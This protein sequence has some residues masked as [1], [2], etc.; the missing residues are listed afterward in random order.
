MQRGRTILVSGCVALVIGACALSLACRSAHRGGPPGVV[1]ATP[2][3]AEEAPGNAE[4]VLS[5]GLEI[6][7]DLTVG[8][9]WEAT[10]PA[11]VAS[12]LEVV[13][14]QRSLDAILSLVGDDGSVLTAD[15]AP[16]GI[17]IDE[18]VA[19]ALP[20]GVHRLRLQPRADGPEAGRVRLRIE[21]LRPW[22]A[23]DERRLELVR[24][25][26][27]ATH[28]DGSFSQADWQRARELS[29]EELAGWRAVADP[30]AI[31][32]TLDRLTSLER[33]LGEVERSIAYGREAVAL[34]L[35]IADPATEAAARYWLAQ[36][37][38]RD[39]QVDAA[40]HQFALGLE[41]AERAGDLRLQGRILNWQGR[42]EG[43]EGDLKT[44]GQLFLR[45]LELRTSAH[46]V[47]GI[48]SMLNNLA[49]MEQHSGD[50][51]L[52]LEYFQRSLEVARRL[53][54]PG[55]ELLAL[56]NKASLLEDRGQW[57][58][59]MDALYEALGR[60]R[61]IGDPLSE[62]E[63]SRTLASVLLKLGES[64]SARE[65]LERAL[66]I[67]RDRKDSYYQ[68]TTL[69]SL[70]WLYLDQKALPDA[71]RALAEAL[72]L[73]HRQQS[74]A[75]EAD[76]LRA[77][78]RLRALQSRPD[79]ALELLGHARSLMGGQR[80]FELAKILRDVAEVRLEVGQ[81][82]AAEATLVEA[83]ATLGDL[84][85]PELRFAIA[86]QQAQT[87]E[88]LGDPRRARGL[89]EFAL[90][91]AEAL[92]SSIDDPDLR[93]L[94][95]S[96]VRE[97]YA[98]TVDVLLELH[99]REPAAGWDRRAFATL[100]RA[101]ARSLVELLS[102]ASSGAAKTVDPDLLEAERAALGAVNRARHALA[103]PETDAPEPQADAAATLAE[104]RRRLAAAEAAIRAA[105]PRYA[106]LR[107]ASPITVDDLQAQLDGDSAV[108][109]FHLH[110][111]RSAVFV[112][113]RDRFAAIPL[114][115][116][117][118]IAQAAA[119]LR[120]TLIQPTRRAFGPLQQRARRL[121]SLL[122]DDAL[123]AAGPSLRWVIIPDGALAYV[124]FEALRVADPAAPGGDR[125]LVEQ[126]IVTYAPSAGVLLSLAD[127]EG[128]PSGSGLV[129]FADPLTLP[130]APRTDGGGVT[131]PARI[132][133]PL[134][135]A[136]REVAMVTDTLPPGSV[137]AFVGAEASET[138]LKNEPLV[139]GARWLH[140]ASHALVDEATPANSAVVLARD[141]AGVDDGYLT[142]REV[143]ALRLRAE[144][145]VL[146]GCETA[147]GPQVRGE[148]LIGLTRAFLYAGA[149]GV[150]V[151]LW[152]VA[153]D[154]TP[155]LMSSFY[156][157]LRQ[158]HDVAAA[159][160]L[161][162]LASL[163]DPSRAHPFHWAPFVLIGGV[164]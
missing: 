88:A 14:E 128:P 96:R 21:A 125:Y 158:G 153:D 161:A 55:A 143:F 160:R 151:S 156:D 66:E 154:T 80:P 133:P 45:A 62:A 50:S 103:T 148:G 116:E 93:A 76:V 19:I 2:A 120:E 54:T 27:Q 107:Y 49:V 22:G 86:Y 23:D 121:G 26:Q 77:L 47:R 142:V 119:E 101:K 145:V 92:R 20:A 159:M 108:L 4:P 6:D 134:P 131:R 111:Q 40:R 69:L 140:L 42:L 60:A 52:A 30:R 17:G 12:Y 71:Q 83:V 51:R 152:K 58:E 32:R 9:P 15:E 139:A 8:E 150:Q 135:G 130:V 25:G 48:T 87:A 155:A 105:A 70:G 65:L 53:R 73:S 90:G 79:D 37:L 39:E 122:L 72:D 132:W 118:T 67:E 126:R 64:Q 82:A 57:Q 13:V 157:F 63:T 94:Y 44:A 163:R 85:A 123:S 38:N 24:L 112:V 147:L 41:A 74:V 89:A 59:A 78:A 28:L 56:S 117:A 3:P 102:A 114:S 81:S 97:A 113:A 99:R 68:L 141:S 61:A 31:I 146:S 84:E 36:S 124:P 149:H 104:A 75:A 11:P 34:S 18:R 16:S 10:V 106:A 137:H 29:L 164:D 33:E 127:P 1:G 138:R 46:D 109:E 115:G 5:V 7:L 35:E 162:K 95:L 110:P 136:R 144:L 98:F 129:A 91:I 100:E 43:R